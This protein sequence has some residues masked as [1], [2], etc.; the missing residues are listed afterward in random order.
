M[1]RQ[2]ILVFFFA[3]SILLFGCKNGDNAG[4]VPPIAPQDD[5]SSSPAGTYD[6]DGSVKRKSYLPPCNASMEDERIYVEEEDRDY[7]CTDGEWEKLKT[8]DDDNW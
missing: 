6:N 7:K 1:R 8:E 4:T 5:D 3:M 2:F